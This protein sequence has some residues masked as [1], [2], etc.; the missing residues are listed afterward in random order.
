MRAEESSPRVTVSL[1]CETAGQI[2]PGDPGQGESKNIL[3]GMAH[4]F[5]FVR[6][7]LAVLSPIPSQAGIVEMTTSV[8]WKVTRLNAGT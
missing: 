5:L 1:E 2:F 7:E 4:H 3:T 6:V 8:N